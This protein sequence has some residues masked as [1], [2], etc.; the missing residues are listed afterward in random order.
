MPIA[1]YVGDTGT[2][3][4]FNLSLIDTTHPNLTGMTAANFTLDL[5]NGQTTKHCIGGTWTVLN[6]PSGVIEYQPVGADI[7]TPGLWQV[8][9]S[10]IFANGPKTWTPDTITVLAKY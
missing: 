4:T 5:F 1:T 3:F 6:G 7:D 8:Y 2:P 10:V 9:L